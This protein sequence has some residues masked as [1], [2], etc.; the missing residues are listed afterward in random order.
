MRLSACGPIGSISPQHTCCCAP[1]TACQCPQALQPPRHCCSITPPPPHRPIAHQARL[2]LMPPPTSQRQ[3][4]LLQRACHRVSTPPSS[5]AASPLL[6]QSAAH[7]QQQTPPACTQALTPA[8]HVHIQHSAAQHSELH[9]TSLYTGA[10]SCSTRTRQY[11]AVQC[12]PVQYTA[13]QSSTVQFNAVHG[14]AIQCSS[15]QYRTK[16]MAGLSGWP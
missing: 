16:H 2:E 11:S 15:M 8:V 7:H 1:V 13:V 9:V 5:A 4:H 3:T 12:S 6:Q 14:R 10:D